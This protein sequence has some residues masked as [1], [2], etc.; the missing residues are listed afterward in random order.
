M[1]IVIRQVFSC[2]SVVLGLDLGLGLGLGL[3]WSHHIFE[4]IHEF[5]LRTG[6]NES[7]PQGSSGTIHVPS[8]G[9]D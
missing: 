6:S 4:L 8:S 7:I 3:V 2:C 5:R 1:V 9:Q